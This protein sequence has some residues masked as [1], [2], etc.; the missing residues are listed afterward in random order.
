MITLLIILQADIASGT[1][2][3]LDIEKQST[4]VIITF[5]E[6]SIFYKR[7]RSKNGQIS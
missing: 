6:I 1:I 3:S 5:P 2:A 7:L 4:I